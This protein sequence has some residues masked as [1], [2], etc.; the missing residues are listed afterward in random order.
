MLALYVVFGWATDVDPLYTKYHDEEWGVPVYND[1]KRASLLKDAGIIRNRLKI[2]A[3][4]VN[5]TELTDKLKNLSRSRK[6]ALSIL[7]QLRS[8]G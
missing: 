4:I 8:G 6:Y 7:P 1:R 2:N 3:V 5:A